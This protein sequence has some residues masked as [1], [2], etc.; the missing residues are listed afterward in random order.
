MVLII[1]VVYLTGYRSVSVL[2]GSGGHGNSLP[3][4][5]VRAAARGTQV[6]KPP[7][8]V[9]HCSV[10]GPLHIFPHTDHD[11]HSDFCYCVFSRV[12]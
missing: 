3:G 4:T 11:D 8:Q 7:V 5:E 9:S 6:S 10:S 12:L 1:T 2:A